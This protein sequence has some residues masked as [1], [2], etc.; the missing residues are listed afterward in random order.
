MEI[1]QCKKDK[2]SRIRDFIVGIL[3][4]EFAIELAA[5][6]HTDI[7]D[8][9]NSYG[10]QREVFYYLSDNNEIVGTAAIKSD[11]EKTALLRRMFVS[12]K[13]RGKGLGKKL[14]DAALGF[15]LKNGYDKVCFRCT[16]R[17]NVAM[18]LCKSYGFIERDVAE[19][20]DYRIYI[21]EKILERK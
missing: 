15:C 11:D 18:T 20:G 7:D 5:Y 4:D 9:E 13:H 21:L 10:G 17:M 19:L 16:E 1:K 12:R 3:H 2:G 6:P 14:L 8:I